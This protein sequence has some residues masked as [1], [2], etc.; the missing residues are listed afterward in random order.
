MVH[1]SKELIS[2][3]TPKTEF[4]RFLNKNNKRIFFS[5]PFGIGKTYFLKEFF[6]LHEKKYDVYYLT[7][8]NY[9][10]SSNENIV[11]FLKYDILVELLKKYSDAFKS[12]ELNGLG[13]KLKFLVAFCK[14]RGLVGRVSKA[15]IKS[16][17]AFTP[18]SVF[19]PLSRLGRSLND[20]TTVREEFKEFEAEKLSGDK[21]AI[22]DF[23][24]KIETKA[25]IVATDYVSQLLRE[26]IEALK[27]GKRS[28]LI[29]DDFDR[30]DPEH[31][32]RILNVLSAHIENDEYNELGFNHI[33]SGGQ[34]KFGFD[35]IIIGGDL[36]N[37]YSIFRHKYGKYTDF[38]G[39]FDKF[40]TVK[41]YFFDNERA[42]A[43]RIPYLMQ[44][45]KY[46]DE[47]LK[48]TK[49]YADT[50]KRFLGE[51]LEQALLVGELNLRQL[52]KP[53]DHLLPEVD[54]WADNPYFGDRARH[55]VDVGI[56]LLSTIYGAEGNFLSVIET[57]KENS[58]LNTPSQEKLTLYRN[59]ASQMLKCMIPYNNKLGRQY[60]LS[61]ILVKEKPSIERDI[62][63]IRPNRSKDLHSRF[64]YEVLFEYVNRP[65]HE[66]QYLET[67]RLA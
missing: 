62:V 58:S 65:E 52:Y 44:F 39:Y 24:E 17:F 40:F 66:K 30:I 26:K 11:E 50:V 7:P 57:I 41:P 16:L 35:H 5:G 6:R 67:Y 61:Y 32:F 3:E 60:W 63:E 38:W 8:V 1:D 18:N 45:I 29:L 2:I 55:A 21:D 25:D 36:A 10:I 64:F 12:E 23:L 51:V 43:E 22:D 47:V 28:V 37:L 46:E 59:L 20:L 4:E 31:T 15:A 49:E 34:N 27:D 53:V 33:E 54:N 9:Q 14:D 56:R 19:N 42:I 13:E 48:G